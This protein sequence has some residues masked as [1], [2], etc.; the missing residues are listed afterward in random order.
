MVFLASDDRRVRF[1][2]GLTDTI[3][4][5]NVSCQTLHGSFKILGAMLE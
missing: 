1:I 3:L 5:S 4:A 2:L